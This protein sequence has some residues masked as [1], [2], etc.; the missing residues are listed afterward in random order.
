MTHPASFRSN[1]I[2]ELGIDIHSLRVTVKAVRT[3][4]GTSPAVTNVYVFM[5]VQSTTQTHTD[6]LFVLLDSMISALHL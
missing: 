2:G 1:Y 4:L 3:T 6:S 5:F